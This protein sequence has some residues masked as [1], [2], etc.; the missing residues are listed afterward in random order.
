V[1]TTEDVE[2]VA[3]LGT[4]SCTIVGSGE[5]LYF[6]FLHPWDRG[7]KPAILMITGTEAEVI[8]T[9]LARRQG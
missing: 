4:V 8:R 6:L 7:G 1:I 5:D 9:W 2:K 3:E